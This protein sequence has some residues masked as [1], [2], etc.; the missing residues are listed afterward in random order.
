LKILIITPSLPYPPHWGFGIRVFQIAKNLGKS[1]EV[2]LLTIAEENQEEDINTMRKYCKA[3]H[4]VPGEQKNQ[5]RYAQLLSLFHPKS[6]LQSSL[7]SKALQ[8]KFTELINQEHFDIIQVESSHLASL[9]LASDSTLVLDEHNIEYM[10]LQRMYQ[11]ERSLVRRLFSWAEF[12]KFQRE[13]KQFWDRADGVVLTSEPERSQFSEMCPGKPV[14]CGPNGVDIDFFKPEATEIDR[15]SIVLTGLMRYR[16]NIDAA[17]FMVNDILPLIHKRRPDVVFSI[18]GAGPPEEIR[19]LASRH[20]VVTDLVPDV[21]PYAQTAGA[22][23]VPLRMGSGTRLKVL[24]GLAMARPMVSTALGCEGID[25]LHD[26]HILIANDA[27]SFADEV[28]KV[29]DEPDLGQRLGSAGRTLVEEKYSWPTVVDGLEQ[30]YEELRTRS[31]H[32]R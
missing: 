17:L 2:T 25:V 14:T 22:L 15:N 21:R 3:V 26:K 23:V 28:L 16:P 6:F 13:E 27:A 20:V 29:L 18:V 30:F 4:A 12:V 24:E 11:T 10:L 7:K 32:L 5:R 9:N 19:R 8:A 1:H 31:S